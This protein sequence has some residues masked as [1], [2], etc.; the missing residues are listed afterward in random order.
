MKGFNQVNVKGTTYVQLYDTV[1][2][3]DS[4]DRIELD[5]GGYVTMSTCKAIN[6]AISKGRVFR[7]RG[8]MYWTNDAGDITHKF[9]GTRL[10]IE[11]KGER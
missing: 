5:N 7:K 6:K 4:G 2:L 8:E 1:V 11:F 10:V 9:N 3:V